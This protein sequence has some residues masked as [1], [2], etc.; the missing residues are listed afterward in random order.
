MLAAAPTPASLKCYS[1]FVQADEELLI[2]E[3]V[4]MFGMGNWAAVA[5]HVGTKGAA[6]CQ[7]HYTSV[8]I[9][10]PA[11]PEPT[12]LASMANVNQLQVR[13]FCAI[14]DNAGQHLG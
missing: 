8:Y 13:Y 2:L 3:G 1:A 9:N 6:D 7:Q 11:F 10:S 4:D 14:P 5:E 12:P